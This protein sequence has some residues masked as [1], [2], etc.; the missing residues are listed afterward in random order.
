M[1]GEGQKP[2]LLNPV[3]RPNVLHLLNPKSVPNQLL[4]YTTDQKELKSILRYSVL[5]PSIKFMKK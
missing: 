4:A 1:A 5:Y 3:T 2:I